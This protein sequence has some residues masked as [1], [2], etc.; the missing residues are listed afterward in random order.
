MITKAGILLQESRFLRF[1]IVGTVAAG[2]NIGAR[3]LFSLAVSFELAVA[4]AFPSVSQPGL[5]LQS[6]SYSKLLAHRCAGN[7]RA[8]HS[9]KS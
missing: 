6:C 1:P 5:S 4:L 8:L 2:T 9:S 7:T 3:V